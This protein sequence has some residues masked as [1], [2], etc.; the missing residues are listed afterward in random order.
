MAQQVV[1]EDGTIL[2][3]L[4]NQA[5][6]QAIPCLANKKN[7]FGGGGGGC[8]SC[9]RKRAAKQ[10]EEM[11]KIKACLV[12]L[13]GEK[14]AQLKQILNAQQIKIVYT[15]SAGQTLSTTF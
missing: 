6:V 8:G 1:V 10:R 11:A 12:A 9:A 2:S 5:A 7:L 14:Q 3:L 15:N 4:N 13:S